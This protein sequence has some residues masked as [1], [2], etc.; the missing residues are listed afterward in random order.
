LPQSYIETICNESY[1]DETNKFQNELRQ[2][3]FSHIDESSRLKTTSLDKLIE[4]RTVALQQQIESYRVELRKA[5]ERYVE[6]E[7]KS[8]PSFAATLEERRRQKERELE[9]HEACRPQEVD[10]PSSWSDQQQYE[11]QEVRNSINSARAH[12]EKVDSELE[13]L[14]QSR[15]KIV[16]E[17]AAAE[18]IGI[19][20]DT[21]EAQVATIRNEIRSDA[22]ALDI[23]IGELIEFKVKRDS[24][25]AA[26]FERKEELQD[27]E[28]SL[29]LGSEDSIMMH[30]IRLLDDIE[31]L[32]AKLD[33]PNQR[34]Q[35]YISE[36]EAWENK[37]RR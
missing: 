22:S 4:K 12:L 31:R 20:L 25:V 18:N 33:E 5:I 11:I 19:R 8:H 30:K 9:A 36:L 6:L 28:T 10:D 27:V 7:E 17:L 13:K 32:S 37:S 21:L 23:N 14:N 35:H 16:G 34:Y 3:I 15:V 24:L 2:V 26:V 1:A 29:S